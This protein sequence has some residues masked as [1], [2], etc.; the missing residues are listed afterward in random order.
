MQWSTQL[1]CQQVYCILVQNRISNSLPSRT[2]LQQL[3]NVLALASSNTVPRKNICAVADFFHRRAAKVVF[4]FWVSS[5]DYRQPVAP[6]LY[7][8][9]QPFQLGQ[10]VAVQV[11]RLIN[12][13]N[14][15]AFVLPHQ[16]AQVAFSLLPLLWDAQFFVVRQIVEERG[17]ECAELDAV[18]FDSQ[19]F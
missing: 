5:K 19:G 4:E 14:D 7:K 2:G 13:E 8:F 17:N 18:L 12:E 1:G 11:M 15:S 10:S 6:I 16:F 3:L 9:H